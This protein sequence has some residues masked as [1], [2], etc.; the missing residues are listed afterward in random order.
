MCINVSKHVRKNNEHNFLKYQPLPELHYLQGELGWSK[1]TTHIK[2]LQEQLP[3]VEAIRANHHKEENDK[4]SSLRYTRHA[5]LPLQ[6]VSHLYIASTEKWR[7]PC[8]VQIPDNQ[9][10]HGE[11]KHHRINS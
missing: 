6:C 10:S 7:V 1:V 8:P 2:Y 3:L 11:I 5:V 9:H 4:V